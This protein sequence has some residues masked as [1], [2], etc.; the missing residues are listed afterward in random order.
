[1]IEKEFFI[2][3][4]IEEKDM[5]NRDIPPASMYMIG[6]INQKQWKKLYNRYVASNKIVKENI[7]DVVKTALEDK[8]AQVR[9]EAIKTIPFLPQDEQIEL[10]QKSTSIIKTILK[11]KNAAV[12][13]EGI[14]AIYF[15]P[16]E[17]R[18]AL[19]KIALEDECY[20]TREE[21]MKMDILIGINENK[22]R[23]GVIPTALDNKQQIN[24]KTTDLDQRMS[25]KS[26]ESVLYAN[27]PKNF[28]RFAFS[29]TGSE[30]TLLGNSL[31]GK[32]IIRHIPF[33]SYLAWEKVFKDYQF[34]RE[35]G[36]DYVP[37]EQIFFVK[38]R[39]KSLTVDV[40]TQVLGDN[41][42]DWLKNNPHCYE[43]EIKLQKDKIIQGLNGLGI[44]HGHI[45]D[46]NFCLLFPK[47]K[48]GI[49]DYSKNPRVYLIDF[50]ESFL[51]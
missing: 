15:A 9:L 24:S 33:S 5:E 20:C 7:V 18:S 19:I 26:V 22:K 50:D 38:K 29:K 12:R 46:E 27:T 32:A 28:S 40:Y 1:M 17:Q 8:D 21:A 39:K 37:I 2:Q 49:D 3:E 11:D 47:N 25:I 13:E 35:Q 14:K 4:N 23:R 44:E 31:K 30:T 6:S 10:G 51:I 48:N 34:W 36:F 41:V 42:S 43:S 45:H 16:K